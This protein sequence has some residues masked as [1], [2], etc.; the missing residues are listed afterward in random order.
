MD[1]RCDDGRNEG[2]RKRMWTQLAVPL[3][4]VACSVLTRAGPP[5]MVV[6]LII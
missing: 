6:H 1:D 3:V 4:L 2:E 5:M